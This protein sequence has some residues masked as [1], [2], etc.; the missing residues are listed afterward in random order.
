M[1]IL[2]DEDGSLRTSVGLK[3]VSVAFALFIQLA[4]LVWGA[5][6]ISGSVNELKSAVVAMQQNL[7]AFRQEQVTMLIDNA[8][9][10]ERIS[11]MERS[12]KP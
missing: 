5:A 6:T 9:R 10:S 4:A 1:T 8:I 11:A 12:L 2:K 7:S 3:N